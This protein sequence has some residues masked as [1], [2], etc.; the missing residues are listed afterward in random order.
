MICIP[1]IAA[2]NEEALLKMKKSA[3]LADV[4]ELRA[5]YI[6]DISLGELIGAKEGKLLITNRKMDEGGRFEGSERERVALLKEAVELGAEYIDIELSTEDALIEE[7]LLKIRGNDNRTKLIISHHD[8]N[9]TPPESE[10]KKLFD[11]CLGAGADIVKIVT[12]ANS[13]EDNLRVL[14]LIPY[15]KGGNKE[16]IAFCMGNSGRISRAA[17]PLL[18]SYLSFASLERGDESVPGQM[19]ASEMKEILRILR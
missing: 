4:I 17:A 5:D 3:L 1:I 11:E 13:V 15:A 18:G 12:Y 2:T 19:T 14:N 7:L 10:L 9:K 6:R 16:I 8:F